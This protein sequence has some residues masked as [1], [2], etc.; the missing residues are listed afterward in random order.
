MI[1]I[2]TEAIRGFKGWEIPV[3]DE[4]NK[5]FCIKTPETVVKVRDAAFY[6]R[7]AVELRRMLIETYHPEIDDDRNFGT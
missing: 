2:L 1:D 5:R 4:V 3:R 7:S 6:K